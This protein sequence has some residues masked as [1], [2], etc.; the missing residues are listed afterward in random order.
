[1]QLRHL[2]PVRSGCLGRDCGRHNRG[3]KGTCSVTLAHP[4][5]A[6]RMNPASPKAAANFL[7]FPRRTE[8]SRRS[9]LLCVAALS[10]NLKVEEHL[11]ASQSLFCTYTTKRNRMQIAPHI[12]R[13]SL[14][15]LSDVSQF[16]SIPYIRVRDLGSLTGA[17]CRVSLFLLLSGTSKGLAAQDLTGL[18]TP[19]ITSP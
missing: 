11:L 15:V 5:S 4:P 12:Y 17:L 14:R 2:R 9:G 10:E 13:S 19:I 7:L 3:A 6:Y 18:L 16:W 8:D 1:M